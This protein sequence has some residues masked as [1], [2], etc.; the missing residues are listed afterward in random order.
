MPGKNLLA[1]TFELHGGGLQI[2]ALGF[3]DH[4]IDDVHLPAGL[5]LRAAGVPD[6]RFFLFADDAA[7]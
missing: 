7:W 3:L 5:Q 4:R 6:R 1:Q 2:L